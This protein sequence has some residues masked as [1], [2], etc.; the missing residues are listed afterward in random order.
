MNLIC[1][2]DNAMHLSLVQQQF[3]SVAKKMGVE[4]NILGTAANGLEGF[5]LYESLIKAGKQVD[6]CTFDIR[7]P[8][9]DGLSA[10]YKIKKMKPSQKIVMAS[11][12]DEKTVTKKISPASKLP[13]P[14]KMNLL[15]KVEDRIISGIQE[16]NKINFILDACEELILDPI[17]IA[18]KYGVSGYLQKPYKIEST[19]K[20]LEAILKGS[21]AFIKAA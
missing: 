11:S 12:E 14:D 18:K 21:T 4:I 8:V 5:K 13:L 17:E 16:P 15:K 6:L 7:M 19:E 10:V 2:D 9:M 20:M 1:V 3:K